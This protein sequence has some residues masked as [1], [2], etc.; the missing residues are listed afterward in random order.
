MKHLMVMLV[1]LMGGFSAS[2]QQLYAAVDTVS[3]E[4]KN[5]NM[6][7]E[8][9]WGYKNMAG[10]WVIYPVFD[11]AGKFFEGMA[12]VGLLQDRKTWKYGFID[13]TGKLV[14]PLMY[15]EVGNFSEGLAFVAILNIV[16][17]DKPA[18]S[19]YN[20][21]GYIDK[22]NKM[23]IQLPEELSKPTSKCYY[24]GQPFA[25]GLAKMY[26]S[27][28]AQCPSLQP[29]GVYRDGRVIMMQE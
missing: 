13:E 28:P 22:T 5:G 25:S 17:E 24:K 9:K 2:G 27:Q 1:L 10:E 16:W 4:D 14:V 19:Q 29:L 21:I 18:D 12:T 20:K 23:V 6:I 15:D 8:L 7:G 3:T 11:H 26:G